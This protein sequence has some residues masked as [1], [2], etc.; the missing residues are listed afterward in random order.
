MEL[1]RAQL[2][3]LGFQMNVERVDEPITADVL[4]GHDGVARAIRFVQTSSAASER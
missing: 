1:P 3:A 2:A 4:L